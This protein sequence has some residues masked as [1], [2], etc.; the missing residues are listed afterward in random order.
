MTRFIWCREMKGVETVKSKPKVCLPQ[1]INWAST[2][3]ERQLRLVCSTSN[4]VLSTPRKHFT[5]P[6]HFIS[7][8]LSTSREMV[9]FLRQSLKKVLHSGIRS[10]HGGVLVGCARPY[11]KG[12]NHLYYDSAAPNI[13]ISVSTQGLPFC[14]PHAPDAK[15]NR[16][17][18]WY[19]LVGIRPEFDRIF[20]SVPCKFKL[21]TVLRSNFFSK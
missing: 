1:A 18:F 2:I 17:H 5:F 15:S 16:L 12:R 4:A 13:L 21:P 14:L 9:F 7:N 3:I 11:K 8:C 19:S 10:Y 6:P 20:Y